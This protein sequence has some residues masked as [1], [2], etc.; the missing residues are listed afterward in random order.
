MLDAGESQAQAA[1]TSVMG[2]PEK[3]AGNLYDHKITGTGWLQLLVAASLWILLPLA[4]GTWRVS[5]T[6]IKSS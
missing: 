3:V 1:G 5:R 4:I 2:R 6:E